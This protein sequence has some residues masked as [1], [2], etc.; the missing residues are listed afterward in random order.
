MAKIGFIGASGL[1]GH[2]M[3]KNLLAQ[4]HA[5]ALT[6]HRKRE[7]VADLLAAGATE[8]TSFQALAEAS[9]IIFIC[10]TGSPQVEAAMEGVLQGA[11]PKLMVVDCSTSEP[12]STAK[13]R[14]QCAAR[15]VTFVDA[16]LARSPVE[17]EA[18]KLNVMVGAEPSV[19]ECVQPILKCFAEN[20]FHVGGPG[21]G[22][23]IKLLNN[24]IGQS[25]CAATAE[26]FAVGQRA[27]V[28]LGQ[29]VSLVSAGPVNSGL[30][31]AMAKT[32]QGD[33]AGLKFELDNARKDVRYYTHLAEGLAIPSLMGEA[34]HQSLAIASA[35]GHGKKFVPSLVE[36]Q[37]QL[38]GAKLIPR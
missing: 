19:F 18:G 20:V 32:L 25:I 28:D 13:L 24:F 21:A 5:L 2:G 11:K 27:G 17:A 10:V 26:A 33:L 16:P 1:M 37:E 12:D 29:L 22:H 35:L 31:Q 38:S 30:F 4:G 6:V 3:A 14:E 15:G 36:A 9:D 7:R 8:A 34:V 23:T